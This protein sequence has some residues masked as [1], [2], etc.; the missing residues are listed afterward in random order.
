MKFLLFLLSFSSTTGFA[1]DQLLLYNVNV[2]NVANGT[3]SQGSILIRDN[4]IVRTGPYDQLK[5]GIPVTN[6][7]DCSGKYIIPGLWDMH[8]S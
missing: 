5:R 3:F 2:V 1:Q 7:V 4:I 8:A 6:Q